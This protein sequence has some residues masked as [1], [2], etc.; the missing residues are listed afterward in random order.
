[1]LAAGDVTAAGEG[2]DVDLASGSGFGR[3]PFGGPT[4]ERSESSNS[5]FG[6]SDVGGTPAA[7]AVAAGG[8]G[9]IGP[10]AGGST[11]SPRLTSG[12]LGGEVPLATPAFHFVRRPATYVPWNFFPFASVATIAPFNFPRTI[13]PV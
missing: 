8:A 7:G 4:S 13:S 1:M 11:S 10:C 12:S 3:I 9:S 5:P 6:F 2:D